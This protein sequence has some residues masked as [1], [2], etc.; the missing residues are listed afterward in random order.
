MSINLMQDYEENKLYLIKRSKMDPY[1]SANFLQIFG[2][3]KILYFFLFLALAIIYEARFGRYI[4]QKL[5][6]FKLEKLIDKLASIGDG[7]LRDFLRDF[8]LM[9]IYGYIIPLALS[10][11][12]L[13]ILGW[14]LQ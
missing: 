9:G 2:L 5:G 3:R 8:L 11:Y 12:T 14:I 7:S 13:L 10:Y 1:E 4:K 6:Y